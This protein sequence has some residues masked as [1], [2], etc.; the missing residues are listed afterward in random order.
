MYCFFCIRGKK[1]PE[2]LNQIRF[3]STHI[4]MLWEYSVLLTYTCM[5]AECIF[6]LICLPFIILW[7]ICPL[8]EATSL[9]T[10]PLGDV[11]WHQSWE[12][13]STVYHWKQWALW[14]SLERLHVLCCAPS[15]APLCRRAILGLISSAAVIAMGSKLNMPAGV[16]PL[17]TALATE[18]TINPSKL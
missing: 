2:P 14:S 1:S 4:N 16:L 7:I 15:P 11:F 8:W 3:L 6:L 18:E 12:R 9:Q 17:V 13:R 5:S 10:K